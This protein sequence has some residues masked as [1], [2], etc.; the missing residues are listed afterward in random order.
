MNRVLVIVAVGL[1]GVFFG[2]LTCFVSLLGWQTYDESRPL[3][4]TEEVCGDEDADGVRVCVQRREGRP[5]VLGGDQVDY[6]YFVHRVDGEDIPRVIRTAYPFYV[7]GLD[8]TVEAGRV[9][10]RDTGY[11]KAVAIYPS[12]F[13]AV[14]DS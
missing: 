9:V 12:R 7:D 1:S 5:G 10:V 13:Y 8:A 4:V 6:L 14:G 2:A 11:S 3:D